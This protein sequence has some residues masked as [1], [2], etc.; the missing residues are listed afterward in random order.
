MSLRVIDQVWRLA[1]SDITP[2]ER[3]VL[4]ALAWYAGDDGRSVFPSVASLAERTSLTRRGVQKALRRLSTG[5]AFLVPDGTGPRGV[6]Q[7]RINLDAFVDRERR[8]QSALCNRE[9]RSRGGEPRSRGGANQVRKGGEP[10]SPDPSVIRQIN[11]SVIRA[12]ARRRPAPVN[13]RHQSGAALTHEAVRNGRVLP[14]PST[15]ADSPSARSKRPVYLGTRIKVFEWQLDDLMRMLGAQATM[16]DLH[17]WFDT[18]DKRIAASAEVVPPRDG[19]RWLAKLTLDEARRR[20]LP[21]AG[22]ENPYAHFPKTWPCD[23]C[24][25]IHE[26]TQADYLQRRCSNRPGERP[27]LRHE[28]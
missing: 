18:L 28:G 3:F 1:S 25:E 27:V 2:I 4:V 15:G 17:Q 22:E 26:G 20:G 24:G 9:P 7:Y 11:P 6:I 14:E 8:S 23:Q 10:G 16:F 19:G 21:I 12:H 5:Q 13:D